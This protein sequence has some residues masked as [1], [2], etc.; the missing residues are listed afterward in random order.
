MAA[1]QKEEALRGYLRQFS[2]VIVAFSGGVDS[3][4]LAVVTQQVLGE[5][6]LAVTGLSPSVSRRQ[7][8][9]AEELVRR[10]GFPHR[11]IETAELG[12]PR[13]V[14][15]PANR[16]Y[17]CKSEL[18]GRLEELRRAEGAETILDGSNADD[19]GDHRP[20]RQAGAER[21]IRS[22]L[23]EVGMTKA[24]I[25]ERSRFWGLPTWDLPAMPCLASRFPY[26][27]EVT[28]EKLAQVEQAEEFLRGLGF[29]E[30]RVRHHEELARI[31][32]AREE[33]PRVLDLQVFERIDQGL[34]RLGY[35]FVTLDL[36]G[37]RSGSLNDLLELDVVS[38]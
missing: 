25:R 38:R 34:K 35:R 11:F 10:F 5:G 30:F 20:G 21:G 26:G 22:P 8:E 4:Y 9:L 27:V 19:L 31:E 15:N 28:P 14:K 1:A 33:M 29:R 7:R 18:F 32:I 2:K 17:Y 24:E 6:M 16:C 3:A 12:D 36:G 13:Y 23:A 37:F